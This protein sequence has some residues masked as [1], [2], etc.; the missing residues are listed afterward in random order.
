[1]GSVS[2]TV[3]PDITACAAQSSTCALVS[4][5]PYTAPPPLHLSHTAMAFASMHIRSKDLPDLLSI[6]QRRRTYL[7]IWT[8]HLSAQVD[9]SSEA[10][11]H[12]NSVSTGTWQQAPASM[13]AVSCFSS[14]LHLHLHFQLLYSHR[15]CMKFPSKSTQGAL[16]CPRDIYSV[17]EL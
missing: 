1:M 14:T 7:L 12:L 10:S 4:L 13:N 17:E 11:S 6:I 15:E 3:Q 2:T 9:G 5:H 16:I 8:A